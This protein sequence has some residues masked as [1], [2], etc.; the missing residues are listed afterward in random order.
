MSKLTITPSS[1]DVDN[2]QLLPDVVVGQATELKVLFDK[3][4]T[5][6]KAYIN[7]VLIP[8]LN[9]DNG[10]KKIGH[11]STNVTA[12]NVG[13]ALE[14]VNAKDTANVKITGNQTIAGVKTFTDGLKTSV[15]PALPADVANRQYVDAVVVGIVSGSIPANSI[16]E[17]QMADAMKKQAGGV[18]KYNDV[19][20]ITDLDTLD[21][22]SIVNAVNETLSTANLAQ[23]TA[24]N[25]ATQTAFNAHLAETVSLKSP[26]PGL[27]PCKGDWN[28]TTGTDDS[29]ALQAIVNYCITNKR[30]IDAGEGKYYIPTPIVIEGSFDSF[31]I[32]GHSAPSAYAKSV[33]LGA[34]FITNGNDLF[35]INVQYPQEHFEFKNFYNYNK[36]E[37]KQGITVKF[38]HGNNTHQLKDVIF[39]NVKSMGNEL[40]L[41]HIATVPVN[42]PYLYF[43]NDYS[44]DTAGWV[45]FINV[46]TTIFIVNNTLVHAT[47]TK[48]AIKSDSALII[49]TNNSWFEGCEP[50]ALNLTND[51]SSIIDLFNT[52]FEVC[53]IITGYGAWLLG[54]NKTINVSGGS[55]LPG[56]L[57]ACS[58]LPDF[59]T[60]SSTTPIKIKSNGGL[61]LT[62]DTV[63][64]EP[65]YTN[66]LYYPIDRISEFSNKNMI[67]TEIISHNYV[68]DPT[69]IPSGVADKTVWTNNDIA[70]G[71][72][73]SL[74]TS[75]EDRLLVAAFIYYA[76]QL[77]NFGLD[78][79]SSYTKNG[80]DTLLNS[81]YVQPASTT[82]TKGLVCLLTIPVN[83]TEN[84][85]A[86][87]LKARDYVGVSPAYLSLVDK[88]TDTTITKIGN[89]LIDKVV[90]TET[91]ASTGSYTFLQK[92]PYLAGYDIKVTLILDDGKKGKI[93]WSMYGL[94]ENGSKYRDVIS[95]ASKDVNVVVTAADGAHQDMYNITVANNTAGTIKAYLVVEYI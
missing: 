4:P 21:K 35:R 41:Q 54:K 37:N 57:T 85:T 83:A 28:G 47:A 18:A 71:V 39:D 22:T 77:G 9:G 19:G 53:G 3:S 12:D 13:D 10:S 73:V 56:T 42:A 25:A 30:T 26:P 95:G 66:Y 55:N 48:G 61:I 7:D 6:E 36:L 67:A 70:A 51:A 64:L 76:V 90:K 58:I 80:V 75:A 72:N 14:E 87:T 81:A 91:I 15:L 74:G 31:V 46:A 11:D 63:S 68:K 49:K 2:I 20:A 44:Y 32:S 89:P 1:I 24:N 5:D 65:T 69:G 38:N 52:Y 82:E 50:T 43:D 17:L 23:G 93:A 94:A 59:C 29:A 78:S 34:T 8:E 60:L 79:L 16:T 92:Y 62:P 88:D 86:L 84:I 40:R 45:E 27:T 33:G